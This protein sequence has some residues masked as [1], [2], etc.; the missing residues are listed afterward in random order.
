M[1][2]TADDI[3]GAAKQIA[4]EVV[5]TPLVPAQRLSL[6]LGCEIFLSMSRRLAAS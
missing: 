6:D 4:G 2:V 1:T 3:R 5:R